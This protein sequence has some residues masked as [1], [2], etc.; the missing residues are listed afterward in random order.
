[1]PREKVIVKGL[2]DYLNRLPETYARK[3]HSSPFSKG[4]PDILGS[5][6]G[7]TLAIEVKQPGQ[8]ATQLQ[9]AELA[10]WCKSGA[11]AGVVTTLDELQALLRG[12]GMTVY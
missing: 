8:K 1:M 12:H 10:K 7:R 4:W 3:T 11:I 2:V 6:N 9:E 5:T